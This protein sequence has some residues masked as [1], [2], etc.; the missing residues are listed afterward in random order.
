MENL[1]FKAL[2]YGLKIFQKK[3]VGNLGCPLGNQ[4]PKPGCPELF[5]GCP[6]RLDTRFVEPC[7]IDPLYEQEHLRKRK[8]SKRMLFTEGHH[9]S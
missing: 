8:N 9:V 6:G 4:T 5:S 2:T 7:I 1:L 3:T